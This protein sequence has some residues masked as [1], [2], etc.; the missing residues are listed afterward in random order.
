MRFALMTEPQQGLHYEE[1]LALARTAEKLGFEAF[2]RS[3]HYASFPGD[4]GL[5]TTDAWATLAGI[6]R[7][8]SRIRLGSLVSPVTF[9]IPGHFAKTV[10]TVD[11]MSG[12]GR[13][14][15]GVGIG[16]NELEH[17][18][19]GLPFPSV[20][21]R[22]AMLQ[23][24]LAM[25]HGFWHEPDGWSSEGRLWQVED[26]RFA[27]R[28]VRADG[29][30]G[31]H[32]I[33]GGGA[34]PRALGLAARYADEYNLSSARPDSWTQSVETLKRACQQIGRDPDEVVRSAMTGVLVAE[35]ETELRDR[36]RQLLVMFGGADDETEPWLEERRSRWIMGTPEQ[37]LERIAL[38]EAGGVQ[39]LMLQDFLPRDLDMVRLI[40]EAILPHA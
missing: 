13:V 16:W 5:P 29:R 19:L 18:Q 22:F 34:K 36:V 25:F 26:T 35:N 1:I 9:R 33:L 2:F 28:P 30:L 6:A 32:L 12:G 27:P 8:T 4:A 23:E 37:A 7:E 11:E 39:R 15:V 10:A 14:E 31:L 20:G 24:Q 21:E 40:G 38:F 17:R 3:D